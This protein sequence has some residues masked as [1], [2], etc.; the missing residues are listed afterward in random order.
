MVPARPAA[1]ARATF[2]VL[3]NIDSYTIS[4]FMT[5][6]FRWRRLPPCP[7]AGTPDRDFGPVTWC[8]SALLADPTSSDAWSAEKEASRREAGHEEEH[9]DHAGPSPGV[10]VR[11]HRG[12][13]PRDELRGPQG[14]G[15]AADRL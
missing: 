4:A 5:S 9:H 11:H 15:R 3:P 8:R 12:A 2:P 7:R 6:P 14:T 1:T 10:A 13:P